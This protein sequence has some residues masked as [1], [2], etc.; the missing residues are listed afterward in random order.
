[1]ARRAR[2]SKC[3]AGETAAAGPGSAPRSSPSRESKLASATPAKPP[4]K[5][6]S[7]SRRLG[8][9]GSYPEHWHTLHCMSLV[10]VQELV[11]VEQHEAELRQPVGGDKLARLRHLVRLRRA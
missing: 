8:A 3:A 10:H 1:M 4:A 2:G 11:G 9:A 6:L 5:R 7:K